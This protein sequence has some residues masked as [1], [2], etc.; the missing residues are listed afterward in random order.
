MT[1]ATETLLR[2]PQVLAR[3][4]ISRSLWWRGIKEGRFPQGVKLSPRV[5]VWRQSDIEAL[6]QALC[7]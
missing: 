7:H 4:S 1:T 2:L 5:T 3:L 6:I